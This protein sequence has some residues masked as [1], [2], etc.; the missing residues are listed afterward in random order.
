[1][2]DENKDEEY[3]WSDYGDFER[4]EQIDLESKDILAIC[5]AS[6][7]TI[8]LPLLI[9]TVFLIVIGMLAGLFS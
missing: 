7:Q 4:R 6:L 8:F 1:M 9:L 2:E 3:N 5:I